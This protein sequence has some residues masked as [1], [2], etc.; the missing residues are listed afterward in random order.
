MLLWEALRSSTPRITP[1][2]STTTPVRATTRLPYETQCA[3][4]KKGGRRC[5]GKAIT[6]SEYCLFHDPATAAKRRQAMNTPAAKRH[7]KLSQIP[8]GY[9]R[10]LSNRAAVGNAMDRLYREIRTGIV[11]PEMGNVLFGILTRIADNEL[12]LT[13]KSK[14]NGRARADVLRPKIREALTRAEKTAWNRAIKNAPADILDRT[15]ALPAPTDRQPAQ[16][17]LPETTQPRLALPQ[18]GSRPATA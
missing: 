10:K 2:E 14:P 11:T 16:K 6:N 18:Q 5:R 15:R 8:G 17:R 1:S 7:R 13:N 4:V 3:A 9:L 12:A